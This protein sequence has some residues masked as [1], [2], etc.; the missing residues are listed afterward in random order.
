MAVFM[1]KYISNNLQLK[2]KLNYF[3][4]NN[5]GLPVYSCKKYN[6]YPEKKIMN[7]IILLLGDSLSISKRI[8]VI[9]FDLH[10]QK[11][12]DKNESITKFSK[13]LLSEFKCKYKKSFIK[14][15]W[16]REQ[17][18]SQSQHYHCALFVDSNIINHSVSLQNMVGTCWK[19]I[20]NGTHVIP[21]NCYY[22]CH[23]SD[24]STLANIIYRLSYLAKNVTKERKNSHTKRYGSSSLT[25]RKK[26][27]KPLYTILSKYIK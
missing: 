18:K 12:S 25:L 20:N 19:E 1:K 6:I 21:K 4:Y 14:L 10:L 15:F 26:E 8:T 17:N 9:R 5:Y 11:Y 7:K 13:K 22:L 16:V 2:T 24:M 23:Q 3:K 27:N